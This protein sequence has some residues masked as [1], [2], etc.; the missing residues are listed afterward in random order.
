[1][2][3]FLYL[4]LAG[5]ISCSFGC[6][7]SD[8][9]SVVERGQ[10]IVGGQADSGHPAAVAIVFIFPKANG[11][12]GAVSCS[13]AIFDVQGDTGYVLTAAHCLLPNAA[14]GVPQPTAAEMHVIEGDDFGCFISDQ[15]GASCPSPVHSVLAL[16]ADP[17]FAAGANPPE[18]AHDLG[19]LTIGGCTATT[20]ILPLMT[21][22]AMTPGTTVDIVGFGETSASSPPLTNTSKLDV[23][24][25]LVSDFDTPTTVGILMGNGLGGTC[26]GDSGGPW[27]ASVGGVDSVGAVTSVGHHCA[28]SAIAAR[29]SAALGGFLAPYVPSGAGGAPGTGGSGGVAGASAAGAGGSAGATPTSSGPA[30]SG[31]SGGCSLSQA[32]PGA[33]ASALYLV[34]L[35]ALCASLRA[36]SKRGRR[37]CEQRWLP[38]AR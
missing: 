32:S 30:D 31:D 24:N 16:D 37:P 33:G 21:V 23:T 18:A 25:T 14:A 8:E 1:V 20:P 2:R 35:M 3:L 36:G 5:A 22:D 10:A 38:V 9:K 34:A 7:S 12:L 17:G 27:I 29:V 13:G 11:K 6:S 19:V 28:Q 15:T 26:D 4:L